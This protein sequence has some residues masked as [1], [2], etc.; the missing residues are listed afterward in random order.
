M[1]SRSL[2]DCCSKTGIWKSR[3]Q[4][5]RQITSRKETLVLTQIVATEEAIEESA[6][7]GWKLL[8][9]AV[10]P[11]P[12]SP[13]SQSQILQPY[14]QSTIT[15]DW[16]YSDSPP[17]NRQTDSSR[18][19]TRS[20]SVCALC[21]R[22]QFWCSECLKTTS[23]RWSFESTSVG[24]DARIWYRFKHSK[25]ANNFLSI[26]S[27]MQK[28]PKDDFI[29]AEIWTIRKLEVQ[30]HFGSSVEFCAHNLMIVNLNL[31]FSFAQLDDCD[32]ESRVF[33]FF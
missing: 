1:P 14:P 21:S 33:V 2:Y 30:S 16:T 23:T 9:Q 7:Q 6:P 3:W 8:Y 25:V 10:K 19:Q 31:I 4:A 29:Y 18:V 13:K 28:F 26:I 22:K 27:F 17:Q 32:Y 15:I 5:V 12:A 11:N 20:W 24:K